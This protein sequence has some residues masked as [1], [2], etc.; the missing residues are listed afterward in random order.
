MLQAKL[1]KLTHECEVACL[2]MLDFQEQLQESKVREIDLKKEL[3]DVKA[4]CQIIP[5]MTSN[6]EKL[7]TC[8]MNLE[9][10]LEC[11][12]KHITSLKS[13]IDTLNSH[14]KVSCN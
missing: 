14:C 4:K 6:E 3:E 7:K 9:M 10:E 2:E 8:I 13:E 1:F 11:K 5:E 12:N